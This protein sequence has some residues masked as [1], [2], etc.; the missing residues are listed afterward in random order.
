M[1]V[2]LDH[3]IVPARDPQ[4]SARFAADVL[5]LPEPRQVGRFCVVETANGV[6]LD[7][8]AAGGPVVSQHY[9]FRIGEDDFDA[10]LRRIRARGLAHWADPGRSRPDEI[11]RR[12]GGR[13]VYFEDP[14]GH[15]LEVLTR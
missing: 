2:H 7:F 8:M 6:Q 9:A 13:G 4:A 15:L 11:N 3:T 10:V 5:G 1:A 14:D 12:N